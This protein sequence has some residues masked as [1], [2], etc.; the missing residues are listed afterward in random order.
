MTKQKYIVSLVTGDWSGDGHSKHDTCNISSN[1]D[2][3]AMEEAYQKA[4]KI[5]GFDFCNDIAAD[6]EDSLISKE[7]LDILI[8]NGLEIKKLDLEYDL[9]RKDFKEDEGEL[10]YNKDGFQ[11][12]GKIFQSLAEVKRA[13]KLKAFA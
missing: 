5:L 10:S 3:K 12:Y 9:K 13:L 7:R 8:K 2:N 1:I 6:Y 4:T 11:L